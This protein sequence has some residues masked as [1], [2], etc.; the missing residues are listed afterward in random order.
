MDLHHSNLH[1]TS[2]YRELSNDCYISEDDMLHTHHPLALSAKFQSHHQDNPMYNDVLQ[3]SEEK[4]KERDYTMVY[5]L[6]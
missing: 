4:R 1:S 6:K 3:S 5:K 2:F